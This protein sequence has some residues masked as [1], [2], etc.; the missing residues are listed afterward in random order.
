MAVTRKNFLFLGS[1]AGGG[2]PAIIYTAL[3]TARLNGIDCERWLADILDRLAR[4]HGAHDLDQLL[5]S[6]WNQP[7][8]LAIAA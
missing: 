8:P 2:R 1:D 4:G 5:P 3:E 7:Q 6:N